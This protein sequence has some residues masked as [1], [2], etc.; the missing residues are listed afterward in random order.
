MEHQGPLILIYNSSSEMTSVGFNNAMLSS[1][2]RHMDWC[3]ANLFTGT[4]KVSVVKYCTCIE[5][6]LLMNFHVFVKF[7]FP[8]AT[9]FFATYLPVAILSTIQ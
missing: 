4:Q 2:S 3:I 9:W 5:R 6:I 7:S 1:E 8:Y